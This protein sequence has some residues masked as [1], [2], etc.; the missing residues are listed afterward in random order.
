MPSDPHPKDEIIGEGIAR[1]LNQGEPPTRAPLDLLLNQPADRLV[2]IIYHKNEIID[3]K[4]A[5][6][7]KT[8]EELA[9][10]KLVRDG[11]HEIC[12]SNDAKQA[13]EIKRLEQE[14][15]KLR[16][17]LE[18][19]EFRATTSHEVASYHID[20]SNKLREEVKEAE[21]RIEELSSG[22]AGAMENADG[23]AVKLGV[24]YE[25]MDAAATWHASV[26]AIEQLREELAS[27]ETKLAD[28]LGQRDVA[29]VERKQLREVSKG[30]ATGLKDA[31]AELEAADKWVVDDTVNPERDARMGAARATLERYRSEVG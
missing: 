14:R 4:Q 27:C 26:K 24:D 3:A 7:N 5:E 23:I 19:C 1:K 22:W 28:A 15:D 21:E 29:E 8:R 17:E 31:L 18:G 16:E 11:S 30:L 2:A 10:V 9:A 20:E 25:E 13:H 6:L 12:W